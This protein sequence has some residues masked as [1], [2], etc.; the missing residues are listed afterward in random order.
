MKPCSAW[1]KS[2][3]AFPELSTWPWHKRGIRAS[4][5]ERYMK[6]K[7]M[8]KRIAVLLL[9]FLF[10]EGASYLLKKGESYMEKKIYA[11]SALSAKPPIDMHITPRIETATFAMG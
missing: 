1:K 7:Q 6:K 9:L 4:R 10:E 5:E 3:I 2:I 11:S 8:A